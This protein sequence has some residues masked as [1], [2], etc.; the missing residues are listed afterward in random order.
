[1]FFIG[2][3]HSLVEMLLIFQYRLAEMAFTPQRLKNRIPFLSILDFDLLAIVTMKAKYTYNQETHKI[4][5]KLD[6]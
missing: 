1:M 5:E 3:I 2:L 4:V 6:K